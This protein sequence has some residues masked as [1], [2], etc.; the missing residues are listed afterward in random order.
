MS[1]VAALLRGMRPR[2]WLKNTLVVAAPFV[3]G[4]LLEPF[5]LGRVALAFAAFCLAASGVYLVNDA[6]D[7]E[8]DRLHP[9]KRD[10]PVAAGLVSPA[11]AVAVAAALLLGAVAVA[12]AATP[13]LVVVLLVYE[14]LQLAYCLWLK[15]E[16]VL[17]IVVVA[18]GFLLR[19]VAGGAATGIDLSQWFLLAA[20]FGS[21]FMVAG[22]RYS[23]HRLAH[24]FPGGVSR[25]SVQRYSATYL[26]FVWSLSAAVLIMTYGLWAFEIRA[27]TH[28]MWAPISMAPFVLAVLRYAVNVDDGHAGEPEDIALSDHVLQL[29]ALAWL[30]TLAAGL[31]L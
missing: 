4:R 22:K 5:V 14:L 12:W 24:E 3:A 26:R 31:Y 21:L 16:P 18:T 27:A 10:R 13:E 9:R 20:S 19:A 2:Q 15:H 25:R 11:A 8:D 28:S 23:E 6:L 30:G 29:V 17:D 1:V 7:A